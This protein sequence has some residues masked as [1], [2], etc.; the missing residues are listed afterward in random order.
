[1]PIE[2]QKDMKYTINVKE[3]ELLEITIPE[4]LLKQAEVV[5]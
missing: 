4:D 5:K 2:M 1:M 3:A